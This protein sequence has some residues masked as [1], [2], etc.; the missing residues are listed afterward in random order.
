MQ[1]PYRGAGGRE[2][3]GLITDEMSNSLYEI[4]NE[5]L[6]TGHLNVLL[7]VG[8]GARSEMTLVVFKCVFTWENRAGKG[9]VIVCLISTPQPRTSSISSPGLS[10]CTHTVRG[11]GKAEARR[12]GRLGGIWAPCRACAFPEQQVGS[13]DRGSVKGREGGE[14]VQS[15]AVTS[16]L[17]PGGIP[18]GQ[19]GDSASRSASGSAET[20]LRNV[21]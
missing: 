3:G 15:M 20:R 7:G 4:R 19:A 13:T 18:R 2:G 17:R 16:A 9:K 12:R 11:E 1:H 21:E 10:C 14:L 6:E 8:W 5:N